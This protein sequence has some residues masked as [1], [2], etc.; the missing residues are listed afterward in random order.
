MI[1]LSTLLLALLITI[2]M[3]PALSLLAIHL[4]VAVDLSRERK[5]HT[6]P[7][8]RIGG[9]AMTV[10]AFVPFLYCLIFVCKSV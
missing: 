4:K 7:V 10:G 2:A 6:R 9:I 5:V 8:P 3:T 1:F